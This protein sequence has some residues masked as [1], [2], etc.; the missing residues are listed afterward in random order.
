MR[1][2]NEN[3]KKDQDKKTLADLLTPDLTVDDIHSVDYNRLYADGYRLALLDVDN[4]L[5]LHGSHQPDEFAIE[6]VRKIQAA[7]LICRIISNGSSRR[8]SGF[9]KAIGLSFYANALKPSTR[10]IHKALESEHCR[11]EQTLLVGD[12]LLT[13]VLAARRAGLMAV[14]VKPR[15]PSEAWNIR[16][17]RLIERILLGKQHKTTDKRGV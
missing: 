16:I 6:A 1:Q 2:K 12:Q 15:S 5:A 8:V 14:L 17:K 3:P 9:A 13:D 7:G 4:T 10:G 11:P